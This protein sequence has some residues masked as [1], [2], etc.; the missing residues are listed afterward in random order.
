[1]FDEALH[2]ARARGGI[3]SNTALPSLRAVTVPPWRSI[4]AYPLEAVGLVTDDAE[5]AVLRFGVERDDT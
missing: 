2:V 5:I 4:I 3:S 1:M